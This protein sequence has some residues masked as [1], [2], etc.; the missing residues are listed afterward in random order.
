MQTDVKGY[1][2]DRKVKKACVDYVELTCDQMNEDDSA[3]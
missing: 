1:G 2:V 3:V